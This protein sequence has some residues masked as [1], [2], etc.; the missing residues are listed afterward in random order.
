MSADW[1]TA[2]LD[3]LLEIRNGYVFDSKRFSPDDGMPLIRIRDLKGA[4][5]T[6]IRYNGPFDSRYI[7]KEGDLLIGM[8]GEFRCYV[9]AGPPALLNQRVCRLQ[10]F[11]QILP[12]FLYY[13][14]NKFLAEIEEHTSFTT[15][16][17][18]SS[19]QISGIRF[20]RPPLVEQQR[21]VA[22]LDEAFEGLA[23]ATANA[24]KNLKNARELFENSIVLNLFGAPDSQ[25]WTLTSVEELAAPGKGTVRTGPFG[26][27]LLHGEFVD[28]GVAVLGIDNAVANEFQWGKR[29]FI[30]PEKYTELSRYTV[31]PGDVLITIMGTCGRCAVVPDDIPTAINSK[32]LCCITLNQKKCL[33]GFLHAY[34]LYHPVARSF[35]MEQAKGSIMEGLNMGIIKELPVWMPGVSKQAEIVEK[36]KSLFG[37]AAI[38]QAIYQR[39]LNALTELKQSLLAKAFAGELT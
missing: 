2:Q 12:R 26:S 38:L 11:N 14:I 24:E 31:K 19:K 28:E 22:I 6:E 29:R 15:V 25:G 39:K 9:W 36:I 21:I 20:P 3:S 16:K 10:E 23:L 32:H 33:P 37:N 35:L 13:G 34:F 27:Q 30:T 17:H 8:D 4:C 7:V 5:S 18:L 1:V